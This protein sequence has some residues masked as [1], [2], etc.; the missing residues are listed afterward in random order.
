MTTAPSAN[1]R[2]AD[3]SSDK[4]DLVHIYCYTCNPT[5]DGRVLAQCGKDVTN[6]TEKGDYTG[7]EPD[8]CVVCIDL[9]DTHTHK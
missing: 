8:I 7:P 1:I 9:N 3:T 4:D 2:P 6:R 5:N